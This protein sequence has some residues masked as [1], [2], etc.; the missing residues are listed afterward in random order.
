MINDALLLRPSCSIHIYLVSVPY[1][2]NNRTSKIIALLAR[3][4]CDILVKAIANE[5]A[6]YDEIASSIERKIGSDAIC[7]F[8]ISNGVSMLSPYTISDSLG[9]THGLQYPTVGRIAIMG[10]WSPYYGCITPS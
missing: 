5:E 2:Q 8:R 4:T 7:Y 3:A 1:V 6:N 10:I 9:H